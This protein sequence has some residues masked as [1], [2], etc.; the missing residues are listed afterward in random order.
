MYTRIFGLLFILFVCKNSSVGQPHTIPTTDY[1]FSSTDID[2]NGWYLNP[3][4]NTQLNNP[5]ALPNPWTC[6]SPG[7]LPT[8][9]RTQYYW[10]DKN[11]AK[12]PSTAFQDVWFP[13][14]INLAGATF[15]GTITWDS[16]S[17]NDDDYNINLYPNGQAGLTAANPDHIEM[18]FD[19]DETIDHF[20]TS[21]WND[22]HKAVDNGSSAAHA[23]IDAKRCIA[24]GI[25]G[26]DCAHNCA[27]ELHPVMALAIETDGHSNSNK[28]AIFVR[29]WG[30]EGYCSSGSEVLD[31]SI[32]LFTF[33]IKHPGAKNVT[34]TNSEF[35]CRG[36]GG[37][38]PYV[39]L[40]PNEG[41]LVTFELPSADKR[42]RING[43]LELKWETAVIKNVIIPPVADT[44][45]KKLL[46]NREK[47]KDYEGFAAYLKKNMTAEQ[48]KIYAVNKPQPKMY[49]D[50]V[51][52]PKLI[53]HVPLKEKLLTGKTIYNTPDKQR[54]QK[55][56][57]ESNALLKAYNGKLPVIIKP[58]KQLMKK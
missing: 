7:L 54:E 41:A 48:K 13:G 58:F 53:T 36:K 21:W 46:S 28:W 34:V 14:H 9:C 55:E 1:N 11:E 2:V 52:V 39:Q 17:G 15:E 45:K 29:N 20:H 19:S 27:S 35:L 43:V 25:F 51:Q 38:G 26:L 16:H 57:A 37:S 22:F 18:E 49:F 5:A 6:Q 10:I 44:T 50:S 3:K 42:E 23:M 4:W 56:M 30:N 32:K 31:P 8:F 24:F 40:V 33:K 47:L 12:C